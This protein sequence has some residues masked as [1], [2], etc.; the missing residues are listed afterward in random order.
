MQDYKDLV[1]EM[2]A[3]SEAELCERN[4]SVEADRDTYRMLAQ[5][6]IHALHHQT[7]TLDR[8]RASHQRLIDDYR[9]LRE[10]VLRHSEAA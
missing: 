1:I 3:D 2:L 10:Q 6:A 8:L 5:E 9:R 4:A 7:I